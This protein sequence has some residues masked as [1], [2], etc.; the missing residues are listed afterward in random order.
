MEPA[1]KLAREGFAAHPYLV[2]IMAGPKNV[3][4]IAVS[5]IRAS[6]TVMLPCGAWVVDVL[7]RQLTG[8]QTARDG[9]T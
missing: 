1:A 8:D 9:C 3:E 7:C 4:R 5:N 6:S 2:Y